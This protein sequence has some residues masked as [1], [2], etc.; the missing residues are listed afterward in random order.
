MQVAPPSPTAS[1][2][3]QAQERASRAANQAKLG[4]V[5]AVEA[6]LPLCLDN[7][8]VASV[9]VKSQARAGGGGRWVD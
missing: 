7:G 1:A 3:A 4:S 5:G 2:D 9:V 6:L 8:G